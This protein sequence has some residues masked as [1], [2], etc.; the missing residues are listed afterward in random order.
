MIMLSYT[1]QACGS[2]HLG[3]RCEA[4]R[5]HLCQGLDRVL[6]LR[7][8]LLQMPPQKHKIREHNNMQQFY[9]TAK[10]DFN[11]KP[12]VL[13]GEGELKAARFLNE[14]GAEPTGG[15]LARVGPPGTFVPDTPGVK[16][17]GKRFFANRYFVTLFWRKVVQYQVFW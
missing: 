13:E 3:D 8:S 4:G 2:E 6:F 17:F 1:E 12:H 15:S 16:V 14:G 10:K 9:M 7:E 11:A 5:S